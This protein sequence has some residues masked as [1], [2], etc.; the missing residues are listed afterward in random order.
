MKVTDEMVERAAKAVE[1][2]NRKPFQWT[3]KQF[4]TW[5]T[6]DR[7]F[8]EDIHTWAHFRGT[9]KEKLLHETRIALEAALNKPRR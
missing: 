8:V 4:E 5:W 9:R 1:R 2:F 3:K 7:L 6:S